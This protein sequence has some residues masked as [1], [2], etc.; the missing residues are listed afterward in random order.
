MSRPILYACTATVTL[1]SVVAG[2]A[3][4]YP[5]ASY[6]PIHA[7]LLLIAAITLLVA[8]VSVSTHESGD[9]AAQIASIT[10]LAALALP[11]IA[12]QVGISPHGII[13][14]RLASEPY[15]VVTQRSGFEKVNLW[16]APWV[17]LLQPC[18]ATASL[19]VAGGSARRR[20]L[21]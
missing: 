3:S 16:V 21:R 19:C 14:G 6:W 8:S 11:L 1:Y 17:Y 10:L 12:V 5:H 4:R 15:P 20:N 7:A 18:L 9:R 2:I 13:S